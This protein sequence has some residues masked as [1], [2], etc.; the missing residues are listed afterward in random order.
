MSNQ[1]GRRLAKPLRMW[2]G[3][4]ACDWSV[5]SWRH[6]QLPLISCFWQFTLHSTKLLFCAKWVV[7]CCVV[8]FVVI[9]Q[10]MV[11][12]WTPYSCH[13]KANL[14]DVMAV[15]HKEH[16]QKHCVHCGCV[17]CITEPGH[18]GGSGWWTW[19]H[20]F[21]E[22]MLNIISANNFIMDTYFQ[23]SR[24]L[25]IDKKTHKISI[26]LWHLEQVNNTCSGKA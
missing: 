26:H 17:L 10:C 13:A 12:F 16:L 23:W 20:F 21:N 9:R 22:T 2:F 15:K 1:N 25:T 18:I 3:A 5:T 7:H 11:L 4:G 8:S 6:S 24:R 19:S 14:L